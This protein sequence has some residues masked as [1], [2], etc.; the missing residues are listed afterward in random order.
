M[1][2]LSRVATAWVLGM[3]LVG[4]AHAQEAKPKEDKIRHYLPAYWS[5]IVSAAQRA[6]IYAIQDKH[7]AEINRLKSQLKAAEEKQFAEME[8]VLSADQKSAIKRVAEASK[9]AAALVKEAAGKS[10]GKT[11]TKKPDGKAEPKSETKS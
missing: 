9:K 8:A 6:A 2:S 10:D 4:A 11:D 1:K 3:A 7:G 5:K